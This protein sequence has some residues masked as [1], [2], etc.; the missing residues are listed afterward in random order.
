MEAVAL[1]EPQ[2]P[3][4]PQQESAVPVYAE[5]PPAQPAPRRWTV[6][7]ALLMLLGCLGIQFVAIIPLMIIFTVFEAV[8]AHEAMQTWQVPLVLL[9]VTLSNL[10]LLWLVRKRQ[11]AKPL[12]DVRDLHEWR[13]W[14]MAGLALLACAAANVA[15]IMYDPTPEVPDLNKGVI[16]MLSSSAHVPWL[17]LAA[18]F[19]TTVVLAPFWEEWFFRGILQQALGTRLPNWVA[20]PLTALIFG[21]MHW[22]DG[23]WVPAVYGLVIGWVASRVRSLAL[24]MLMHGVVNLSVFILL[25]LNA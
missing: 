3:Q 15:R 1:S 21:A 12:W 18:V 20:I 2:V 24:P 10:L 9:V 14:A 11:G 22:G 23:W 16:D 25:V 5:L 4:Q 17:P 6:G 19:V 8:G 7:A 13:S